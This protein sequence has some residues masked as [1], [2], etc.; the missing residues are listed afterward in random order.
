MRFTIC[1]LFFYWETWHITEAKRYNIECVIV[2]STVFKEVNAF[3]KSYATCLMQKLGDEWQISSW[4]SGLQAIGSAQYLE[5]YPPTPSS[6][7]TFNLLPVFFTNK[8][9]FLWC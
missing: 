1:V 3:R 7:W 5:L 2:L 6:T 8:R 4:I 9:L